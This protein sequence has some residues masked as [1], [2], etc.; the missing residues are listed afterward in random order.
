MYKNGFSFIA[1]KFAEIK[2]WFTDTKYSFMYNL[3]DLI[4]Y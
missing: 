1:T 4:Q 3:I 2:S